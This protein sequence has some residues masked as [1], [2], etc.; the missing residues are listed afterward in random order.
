MTSVPSFLRRQCGTV[1]SLSIVS[2][3]LVFSSSSAE[4]Y[5]I[6]DSGEHDGLP[7]RE[8]SNLEGLHAM[9]MDLLPASTAKRQIRTSVQSIQI[10]WIAA[11]AGSSWND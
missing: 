8:P 6:I 10:G 5:V 3:Y 11:A 4:R 7:D 1:V 2:K 9:S